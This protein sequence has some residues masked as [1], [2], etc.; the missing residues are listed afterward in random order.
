M[1]RPFWKEV[2]NDIVIYVKNND[3]P[4]NTY[5][6]FS[7]KRRPD[8][9]EE[10]EWSQFIDDISDLIDYGHI[11]GE[12]QLENDFDIEVGDYKPNCL[13]VNFLNKW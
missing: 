10:V 5:I 4:K 13:I 6:T 1:N 9:F 11:T 3:I 12:V 8:N 7:L 2:I